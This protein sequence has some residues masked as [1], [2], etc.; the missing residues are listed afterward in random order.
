MADIIG[1]SRRTAG[2]NDMLDAVLEP[3]SDKTAKKR[4]VEGGAYGVVLDDGGEIVVVAVWGDKWPNNPNPGGMVRFLDES[5]TQAYMVHNYVKQGDDWVITQ[6]DRT[7]SRDWMQFPDSAVEWY[8]FLSDGRGRL[9]R[10]DR[11]HLKG[12]DLVERDGIDLAALKTAAPPFGSYEHLLDRKV[13]ERV[14][15]DVEPL[16]WLG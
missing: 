12:V 3:L 1:Y 11:E 13:L 9:K 10:F 8:Q 6:I 16:P 2:W 7:N 14:W 15:A 5:R 4:H